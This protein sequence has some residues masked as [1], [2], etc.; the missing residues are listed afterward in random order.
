MA[1]SLI[2]SRP[3][4]GSGSRPRAVH[5]ARLPRNSEPEPPGLLTRCPGS[6]L[7][8]PGCSQAQLR[9]GRGLRWGIRCWRGE[10]LV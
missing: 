3:C 1:Y 5:E 7:A 9:R 10:L 8:H 6:H 2:S 4:T